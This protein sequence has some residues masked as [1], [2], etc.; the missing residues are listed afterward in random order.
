MQEYERRLLAKD[1]E[2]QATKEKMLTLKR[3]MEQLTL[4]LNQLRNQLEDQEHRQAIEASSASLAQAKELEGKV[5]EMQS[6]LQAREQHIQELREQLDCNSTEMMQ[7]SMQLERELQ[8]AQEQVH[9]A[10]QIA[11]NYR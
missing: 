7:R 10:E 9:A 3:N 11:A 2:I 1:Q 4:Q 8:V 5:E 6:A